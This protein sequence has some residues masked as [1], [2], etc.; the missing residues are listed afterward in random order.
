VLT[1]ALTAWAGYGWAAPAAGVQQCV[2]QPRHLSSSGGPSFVR[3]PAA[4][5]CPMPMWCSR[6]LTRRVSLP[7][8]STR[9]V[10][11]RS[12]L[13]A[14]RSL[15]KLGANPGGQEA[16]VSSGLVRQLAMDWLGLLNPA[17]QQPLS[18]R[19]PLGSRPR[20]PLSNGGFVL[21]NDA[22]A[23]A[24]AVVDRDALVFRL[25]GSSRPL[26]VCCGTHRPAAVSSRGLAGGSMWGASCWR[27]ALT[28]WR[29]RSIS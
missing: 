18:L 15:G 1:E 21:V 9:S 5:V 4:R 3:R 11:T 20:S 26:S 25:P 10:R 2:Q 14:V 13:S 28:L 22:G 23:Y 29:L 17:E 24:P 16:G 7:S 12:W 6:P 27:N 19:I 8:A